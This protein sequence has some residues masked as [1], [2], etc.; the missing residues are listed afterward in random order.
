MSK[1]SN[2]S[3]ALALA[4]VIGAA[5]VANATGYAPFRPDVGAVYTMSNAAE[6]NAVVVYRRA[7]DGTLSPSA[8]YPTGGSGTGGG[9]GNQGGLV[10]SDDGRWLFAVNAGSDELSMF[11]VTKKGLSLVQTVRS[12]GVRPVSVSS[13]DN[14]VYVLN[15]GS[16]SIAG[17]KVTHRGKLEALPHSDRSL[18]RTG[19]AAAQIQFSPGGRDLVISEKAT[20][21]L[22]VYEVGRDG[23]PEDTPEVVTSVGQ[24]PFGFDFGKHRLLFVSEAAGGA[25]NASSVSSYRLTRDGNLEPVDG[26][27]PTGQT[28][29]CWIVVT[30]NGRHL[31][32]TVAGSSAISGYRIDRSGDL[33]LLDANGITASTGPGSVPIDMAISDNGNFLYALSTNNQ[34]ISEFRIRADGSLLPIGTLNAIP[35]AANGLAAR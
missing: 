7:W 20:N 17:F 22:V 1:A 29:A 30:P 6:G 2:T 27:A 24:T 13:S 15:A 31:Y 32:T 34:T 10:L 8:S 4:G 12:G 3:L 19:T 35:E 16:D 5:G 23:L 9:L 26:A 14:L 21:K 25:P 11:A 18:S 28:A 33:T